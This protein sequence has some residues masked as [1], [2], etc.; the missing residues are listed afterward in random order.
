MTTRIAF[1]MVLFCLAHNAAANHITGGE[2]YYNYNG[3]FNGQHQYAVTLKLFMRCNSGRTFNNPA[4]IGVFS[5]ADNSRVQDVSVALTRTETIRLTD[6]NKCIT[7]PPTVCYEVGYYEFIVTLPPSVEGYTLT[8]QVVYRVANI[9]NLTSGYGNIGA[10]YTA[11]IPGTG[12]LNT[13]PA[14]KSANFVG[15]DLVVICAGNSFSYS[16]AAQDNDGDVLRYSFREALQGGGNAGANTGIPAEPPPYASVP[17]STI[18]NSSTPLGTAVQIDP[19]TGLITGR[20]PAIAGIYVVTVGVEEIRNGVVIATQRKDIQINIAPCTIAGAQ[21]QPEYSVCKDSKTISLINL[22]R[23]PLINS[24]NWELFNLS[25]DL[26]YASA[27]PAIQYTFPDTGVFNIKLVIN[28]NRDCTD[29]IT[30]L[31]RVY[32]GFKPDFSFLGVC[33]KKPTNFSDLS[34]TVYGE[35]NSW[36][37][38]LGQPYTPG[39]DAVTKTTIITY[40][41]DGQKTP[42][43]IVGNSKGCVDTVTKRIAIVDRPPVQLAFSDTLICVRDQLVL[44]A[45]APGT[46]SWSPSA[47]ISNENTSTPTVMPDRTTT[48]YVDLNDD[49]CVNRDSVKVRVTDR[50]SLTAMADTTI[51]Q[52]DPI[53]LR[54]VSDAF[55]YE[56]TPA[57]QLNNSSLKLPLAITSQTTT[58]QVKA[59]IGGCVA[60]EDIR[61]TAVPFPTAYAGPDTTICFKS[62]AFLHGVS[63]APTILWTSSGMIN[64]SSTLSAMASPATTTSYIL[65]AYDTKG[66]PKPGRDTVRVTVLPK[67]FASAGNDTAV[68]VGQKLQLTAAAGAKYQWFP[69]QNLSASNIAN[70]VAVFTEPS[71]GLP[72]KVLV[73]NQEGCVDSAAVTIR[74]FKTGPDIFVPSA[75]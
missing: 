70:P 73:Y 48:Y 47:N 74:V 26:L 60:M 9:A 75:F 49:G 53:R 21:L 29:S 72:Y 15:S 45:N 25:G 50:V 3:I 64:G 22:S 35:V 30:S 17:Y 40:L 4:I 19:S 11:E 12:S 2:M 71:G 43:L 18:Y 46:Y 6:P 34:T 54:I 67:I 28:R 61:V 51:C 37:W 42:R 66:C 65:S 44:K 55:K 5:K 7:D 57:L 16:F 38:E 23:S 52:N 31:A 68:V 39:N 1:M 63:D 62:M 36:I 8:G 69:S 10:T 41:T 20:A 56:W 24:Q 13:A 59:S 58:Y 33:L 27:Q 14:N 32:P